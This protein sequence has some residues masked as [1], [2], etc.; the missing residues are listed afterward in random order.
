MI[1]M[2]VMS[3]QDDGAVAV[4]VAICMVALI[5]FTALVVD[6]GYWF[7]V[8]RQLQSSADAAALA[9]C[10]ELAEEQSNAQIWSV[11]EDFAARNDVIP[12][13]GLTVIAPTPDGLS[14]IGDNFVKVTVETKSPSFFGRIFGVASSDIR[15][16][17]VASVGYLVGAQTPVPWALPIMRVDRVVAVANG[18]EYELGLDSDGNYTGWLPSGWSGDVDIIAYNNQTLDPNFPNGVPELIEDVAGASYIP[19]TAQYF[20]DVQ[21]SRNTVTAYAGESVGVQVTVKGTSLPAGW[22]VRVKSDKAVVNL[23]TTNGLTY[24]GSIAVSD[25]DDPVANRTLT[26]EVVDDKNKSVEAVGPQYVT[27]RRSTHPVKDIRVAP[28]VFPAGSPSPTQ[29]TVTMNDY[30]YGKRYEMKV[31]GGGG[32][33]GNFMAV[34]FAETYH[35]PNWLPQRD[36]PEYDFGPFNDEYYEFISGEIPPESPWNDY[37][38]HV[39]DTI[40][41]QGATGVGSSPKIEKALEDRFRPEASDFQGWVDAGMPPSKRVVLVPVTEKVQPA[42]GNSPLRV[43]SFAA[44]Y[45]E[46]YDK[47]DY[48]VIGYFVEYVTSGWIVEDT[49]PDPNFAIKA[50]HLTSEHL[51]F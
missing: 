26:F 25:T 45:V 2:F 50:T 33:V 44:M 37:V 49:P 28:T 18:T 51:D 43:V 36:E 30:E 22:G 9:G 27:V 4:I 34:N 8:K 46:D 5:G 14:D 10:W 15:A 16:Q 40:W 42:G 19:A 6:V 38:L 39:G 24:Q 13:D 11:V 3:R 48:S 31:A 17:S 21:L 7:T 20:A 32:D 41:T 1:G 47:N 35:T 12:V 23:N 29:I